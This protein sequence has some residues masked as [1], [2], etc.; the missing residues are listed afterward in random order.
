MLSQIF[1]PADIAQRYGVSV[2][3]ARRYMREMR[4]TENPL[5]VTDEAIRDWDMFRTVLPPRE[6]SWK[7]PRRR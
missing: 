3:T 4:H 6:V 1:K 7:I 5:T 2:R